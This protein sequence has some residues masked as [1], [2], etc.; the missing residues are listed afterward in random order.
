MRPES[1]YAFVQ[2]SHGM[3]VLKWER[4]MYLAA[5][6]VILIA[7][8]VASFSFCKVAADADRQS[9]RYYTRARQMRTLIPATWNTQAVHSPRLEVLRGR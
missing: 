9:R 7:L 1:S 3:G 2:T 8:S 6:I 4:S 5:F